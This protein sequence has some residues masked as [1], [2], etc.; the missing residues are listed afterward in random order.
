MMD[1]ICGLSVQID[2]AI[3]VNNLVVQLCYTELEKCEISDGF[4]VSH[5]KHTS[6]MNCTG[7]LNPSYC[8][9]VASVVAQ[10]G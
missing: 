4:S 5:F 6:M 3:T 1:R 7:C 9:V 10:C 2:P 8:A